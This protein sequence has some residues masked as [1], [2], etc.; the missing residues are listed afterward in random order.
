[1]LKIVKGLKLERRGLE[2]RKGVLDRVNDIFENVSKTG[3]KAIFEYTKKFD[4]VE[5]NEGNI[6]V[7][8]EEIQL[9]Y[10]SLSKNQINA[11]KKVAKNIERFCKIERKNIEPFKFKSNGNLL[12]E[13]VKSIESVGCYIPAGRFPLPS[14]VLMSVIPAKVAGVKEIIICT[15]PMKKNGKIIANEAVVVAADVLGVN[16]IFKVGGAQ[17]I[18]AMMFGTKTIPKVDKI[19]G[20]G[21]VY[22]AAAKKLAYGYVDIDFIAGPSELMIVAD[23]AANPN[24]VAADLLAEAEHDTDAIAVLVT[25]SMKLAK[26]V[27][28]KIKEQLEVLSTKKTA[29]E[30]LKVNGKVIITKNLKECFKITNAFAPEHLEVMVRNPERYLNKINNAGSIFLGDYSSSVFG[31]YISGTNHILP[32]SGLARMRGG[33]SVRDFIKFTSYQKIDKKNIMK[34]I[35]SAYEI[36]S[37]EG[38]EGH[39]KAVKIRSE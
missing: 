39:A 34:L 2:F 30:S 17:A 32:T 20:P 8:K 10:K 6:L 25:P 28:E 38:L 24:F 9:A 35:K 33:L 15:P 4:E 18:A 7:T 36:A 37:L 29:L 16:K 1:M 11:I 19:V 5:L 31:D 22:V 21:N 3:D 13:V 26:E 12:G 27:N 23:D 14:T